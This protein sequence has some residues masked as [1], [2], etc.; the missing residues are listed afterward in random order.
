MPVSAVK[1]QCLPLASHMMGLVLSRKLRVMN[2]CFRY[3]N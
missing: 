3:G 2:S 1:T